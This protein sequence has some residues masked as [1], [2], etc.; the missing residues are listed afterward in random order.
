MGSPLTTAVGMKQ[1]LNLLLLPTLYAQNTFNPIDQVCHLHGQHGDTIITFTL[2]TDLDFLDGT[3]G[4]CPISVVD[5]NADAYVKWNEPNASYMMRFNAY[6]CGETDPWYRNVTISSNFGFSQNGTSHYMK[7]VHLNSV[8][9]FES[10]NKVTLDFGNMTSTSLSYNEDTISSGMSFIMRGWLNGYE[11]TE[12]SSGDELTSGDQLFVTLKST[13]DAAGY[14]VYIPERCAV[15]STGGQSFILFDVNVNNGSVLPALKFEKSY[16]ATAKSWQFAYRIF[17]FSENDNSQHSLD[18]DVK[19]CIDDWQNCSSLAMGF[20][21]DDFDATEWVTDITDLN[22]DNNSNA[23]TTSVDWSSTTATLSANIKVGGFLGYAIVFDDD[24]VY[25]PGRVVD[26]T[27]QVP[28]V[29][30]YGKNDRQLKKQ[31]TY[32]SGSYYYCVA[33]N[34]KYV[35]AT[36]YAQLNPNGKIVVF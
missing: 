26:G 10:D 22:D 33:V 24:H 1:L 6:T 8:C 30:A 9:D 21:G 5:E 19:L 12:V 3:V 34:D 25:V 36:L 7:H 2:D 27:N 15:S 29:W 4:T 13:V 11:S 14:F 31:Y 23:P 18:C 20:L 32:G 17:S 16:N 28:Y 35:I